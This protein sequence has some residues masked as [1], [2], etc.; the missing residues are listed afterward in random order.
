MLD[1]SVD[2]LDLSVDM[3]DLSVDM[4]DLSVDM[5][6]LSVDMLDLSVDMLDL[7]VD[8]ISSILQY[9]LTNNIFEFG[10]QQYQQI[11]GNRDMKPPRATITDY[12]YVL[13]SRNCAGDME[14]EAQ[15]VQARY[16]W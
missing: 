4:L 6:D 15:F 16:W 2:M 5:L 10:S 1:L 9:T 7:S 3:L 12:L 13:A 8:D 14:L 11:E